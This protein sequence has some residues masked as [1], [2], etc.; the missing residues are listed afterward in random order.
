M[1]L[2]DRHWQEKHLGS[3]QTSVRSARQT[4]RKVKTEGNRSDRK[5][6]VTDTEKT[7]INEKK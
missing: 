3:V 6:F 7:D 5:H 1:D 2:L 4:L